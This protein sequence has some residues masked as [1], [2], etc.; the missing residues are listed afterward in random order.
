MKKAPKEEELLLPLNMLNLYTHGAFP[1]GD[2]R[3]N[4]I[5]WYYPEIRTIIP[6][7]TFN[8]PRSL[9]KFMKT[10]PFEFRYD[11]DP[12]EIIICCSEREETW[13][14]PKLIDAYKNLIDYGVLHSVETWQEGKLAG[15]LYGISVKGAFFGESMFSSVSQASKCALVKL[16][17]R[18][19]EKQFVVL[20]V[21]YENPHLNMFGTKQ[22]SLEEYK[23]ML[24]L[25]YEQNTDFI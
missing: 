7:D 8:T 10:A 18:L 15:G 3:T 22:I 2:A 6:L 21:Q 25:A 14:T 4:K 13:I 5:D 17:E 11:F 16:V 9:R 12:L 24:N 1:M 23:E 20:D 19:K